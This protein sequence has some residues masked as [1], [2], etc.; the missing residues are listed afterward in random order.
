MQKN[1]YDLI[2][3]GGGS[4]RVLFFMENFFGRAVVVFGKSA[5]EC[6]HGVESVGKDKLRKV[7]IFR[8]FCL[9]YEVLYADCVDVRVERFADVQVEQAGKIV[10]VI[11]E[12]SRDLFE[13]DRL[14]VVF[15]D[16]VERR[17][18]R[19]DIGR[20][21]IGYAGVMRK[22]ASHDD[23]DI[24]LFDEFGRVGVICKRLKVR[25]QTAVERFVAEERGERFRTENIREIV[26]ISLPDDQDMVGV[27]GRRH[28]FVD[29]AFA[30]KNH[31]VLPADAFLAVHFAAD[32]AVKDVQNFNTAVEVRGRVGIVPL[33]KLHRV[34]AVVLTF[35]VREFFHDSNI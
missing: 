5:V 3:A 35:I 10:F 21:L 26:G 28:E 24:S 19:A 9:A 1:Y 16:V 31:V 14:A 18:D 29:R 32:A 6:R 13:R 30:H 4:F 34:G 12:V 20:S 11:S 15:V 8:L 2:V 33:K 25:Q 27:S 17:D 23:V 7:G 22:Q